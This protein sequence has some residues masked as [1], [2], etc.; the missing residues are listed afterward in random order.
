MSI[1]LS[2]LGIFYN[3]FV[4]GFNWYSF[5]AIG[6]G[7]VINGI[8]DYFSIRK[9]KEKTIV[10]LNDKYLTLEKTIMAIND[11]NDEIICEE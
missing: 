6:A 5:I 3:D 9:L 7:M 10:Y 1:F 2:L 8:Y 4:N 11:T